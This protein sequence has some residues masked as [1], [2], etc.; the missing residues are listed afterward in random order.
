M[1][2]PD[3]PFP[4]APCST[5][6]ADSKA[7]VQATDGHLI[8]HCNHLDAAGVWS[9]ELKR[10]TVYT[11]ISAESFAQAVLKLYDVAEEATH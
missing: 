9:P 6:L 8:V 7:C 3:I 10:W 4:Q 1:K 5:C 11:P 2:T